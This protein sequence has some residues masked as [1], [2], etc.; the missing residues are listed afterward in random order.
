MRGRLVI[1]VNKYKVDASNVLALAQNEK[2]VDAMRKNKSLDK[3]EDA[4]FY[5][6]CLSQSDHVIREETQLIHLGRTSI[7]MLVVDDAPRKIALIRNNMLITDSVPGFWK[8]I[9]GLCWSCGGVEPRRFA[10]HSSDGA[11]VA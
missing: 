6:N 1:E 4:V 10:I 11:A 2:I 8:K 9:P 5:M 3:L 7:R